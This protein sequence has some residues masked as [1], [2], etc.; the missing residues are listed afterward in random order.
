MEVKNKVVHD[1]PFGKWLVIC[2]KS[3]GIFFCLAHALQ[4]D[5][6]LDFYVHGNSWDSPSAWSRQR[7]QFRTSAVFVALI[8]K[9]FIDI[10][11]HY[12][13]LEL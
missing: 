12:S 11:K 3:S 5:I 10:A 2:M 8:H 1:A 9:I 4:D 7:R 13:S 6:T